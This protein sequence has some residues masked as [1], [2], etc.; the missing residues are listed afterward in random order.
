MLQGTSEYQ[1]F[2]KFALDDDGV[3]FL[4]MTNK[5]IKTRLDTPG[6][7]CSQFHFCT[8]NKAFIP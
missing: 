2:A 5:N 4:H 3:R 6:V 7:Q 8:C 1:T